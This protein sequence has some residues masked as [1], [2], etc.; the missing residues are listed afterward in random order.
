[1]YSQA[2]GIGRKNPTYKVGSILRIDLCIV[3]V[4]S[5]HT[6]SSWEEGTNRI[7]NSRTISTFIDYVDTRND[8]KATSSK[9]LT[10]K[11]LKRKQTNVLNK[12]QNN[13]SDT[14]IY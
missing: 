7:Y 4:Y 3:S 14:S 9:T 12:R 10:I 2:L 13:R 6:R 8:N 11:H 1:M 5:K